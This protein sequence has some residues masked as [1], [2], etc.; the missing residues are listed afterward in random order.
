MEIRA[1]NNYAANVADDDPAE[2]TRMAR[3]AMELAAEIGDR[4]MYFWL[5]GNLCAALRAEGHDWDEQLTLVRDAYEAATLPT[6]RARL[7]VLAGLLET[8]RGENLDEM[9]VQVA[10]AI[11]SSTNPEQIFQSAMSLSESAFARGDHETSYRQAMRAHALELQ[12]QSIPLEAAFYAATAASDPDKIREVARLT[13][14]LTSSG[15]LTA[16]ARTANA[17]ALAAVEG[18]TGEA[19]AAFRTAIAELT[20]LEQ[21]Y[22]AARFTVAAATLLPNE[23][24]IRAMAA[25]VRP[26]LERLGARPALERLDLALGSPSMTGVDEGTPA[27]SSASTRGA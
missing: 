10:E 26:L 13:E 8:A 9:E 23:P 19:V 25:E 17:A 15:R 24:E 2:A 12:D 27:P 5:V 22:D 20:E 7:R 1:R 4:G 16:A 21:H 6:D 18:R 11:G 14:K 3:G